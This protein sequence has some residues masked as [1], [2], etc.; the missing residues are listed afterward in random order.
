[1]RTGTIVISGLTLL[2]ATASSHAATL[3]TGLTDVTAIA[4]TEGETRLLCRIDDLASVA[5]TRHFA[6]DRAILRFSL[7]GEVAEERLAVQMHP[8][9]RS[10]N[11]GT[12]DWTTG[13]ERAG[14][15]FD[16]DVYGR[17][18]VDFGR[19]SSDVVL[20]ITI[21]VREALLNEGWDGFILR[22]APFESGGIPDGDASRFAGLA[23]AQVNITYQKVNRT[24]PDRWNPVIPEQPEDD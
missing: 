22:G 13:W 3:T 6:V 4:D 1:M 10:W 23:N 7:A 17:A 12:V 2:A 9:T 24:P 18:H 20:D 15:D 5:D 16:D 14:G 8:V 21:P 11:P 19:A